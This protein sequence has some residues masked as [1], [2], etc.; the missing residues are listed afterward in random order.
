ML[1]V[2]SGMPE[3]I[4]VEA[5]IAYRYKLDARLITYNSDKTATLTSQLSNDFR[6]ITSFL[7]PRD[8]LLCSS[9]TVL[10]I[11]LYSSLLMSS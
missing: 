9:I 10:I 3:A 11:R 6:F 2:R 5:T 4:V 8:I 1:K 7:E